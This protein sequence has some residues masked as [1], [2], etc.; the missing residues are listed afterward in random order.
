MKLAQ[1]L[2]VHN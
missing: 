2:F 1:I